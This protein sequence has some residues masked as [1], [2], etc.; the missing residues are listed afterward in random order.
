MWSGNTISWPLSCNEKNLETI[1]LSV[2]FLFRWRALKV[3]PI[4]LLIWSFHHF[5]KF[6]W[7]YLKLAYE[8][9]TCP[10]I[11]KINFCD[12]Y[13]SSK[14]ISILGLLVSLGAT[15][16]SYVKCVRV[17][18]KMRAMFMFCGHLLHR[19]VKHANSMS[20]CDLPKPVLF[21]NCSYTWL[22]T[23]SL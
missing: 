9:K 13:K 22:L 19:L 23:S 1:T 5:G 6:H 21:L 20:H 7:Q 18:Y 12:P 17:F 15:S 14:C 8:F 3:A 4:V 2:E 11:W 10:S 16:K